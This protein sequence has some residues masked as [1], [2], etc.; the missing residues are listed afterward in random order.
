MDGSSKSRS[1]ELAT[2][3]QLSAWGPI[4]QS[5]PLWYGYA[6]PY[7]PYHVIPCHAIPYLTIPYQSLLCFRY[8]IYHTMPYEVYNRPLFSPP[9]LWPVQSSLPISRCLKHFQIP[10]AAQL[11]DPLSHRPQISAPQIRMIQKW[12]GKAVFSMNLLSK[13]SIDQSSLLISLP[14]RHCIGRRCPE[15]HN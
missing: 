6:I 14:S 12:R 3:F 11:T 13:T 5:S 8:A 9:I 4:G 2:A 7:L 10:Q 1:G 15:Q